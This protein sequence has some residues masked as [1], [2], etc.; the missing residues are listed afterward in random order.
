MT[1]RTQLRTPDHNTTLLAHESN[2]ATPPASSSLHSALRSLLPPPPLA[3]FCSCQ[4]SNLCGAVYRTGNVVFTPDGSALLSPTGNRITAFHLTTHRTSTLPVALPS[5]TQHLALS[6]SGHLLLAIDDHGRSLF[7]HYAHRHVLFEFAFGSP[8]IAVAFSPNG[9]YLAAATAPGTL[10]IYYTPQLLSATAHKP[11]TTLRQLT[12]HHAAI[13]HIDWSADSHYLLTASEDLTA[14]VVTLGDVTGWGGASGGLTLAGHR[15]TVVAAYWATPEGDKGNLSYRVY[16]ISQDGAL[17]QWRWVHTPA[18][19]STTA[20]SASLSSSSHPHHPPHTAPG[21][22]S[23]FGQPGR[24]I[25]S[26]KHFF[27]SNTHQST[28]T[29][30]QLHRT[31]QGFDLLLVAFS[32]GSFSLYELPAFTLIHSL[33]VSSSSLS[34]LAISPSSSW[35]AVGSSHTSSLLVWEWQSESYILRQQ[36][37]SGL[38]SCLAY[39]PDSGYIATGGDDG[40]VKVWNANSGYCFKTFTH[41]TAPVTSVLFS[42]AG[43][44]VLSASSDGTVHCY[45]LVRYR[46]F[47]TLTAPVACQFGAMC[48][49]DKGELVMVAAA[50]PF[51]VYV[52]ALQT[53]RL[54]DVLSGHE[55]PISE[56]GFSNSLSLLLS[57]SWDRTVR[58]WDPFEGKG[59]VEVLQHDSDVISLAVR[60]DG[61]A[62]ATATL[63]GNVHVWDIRTATVTH[64]IEVGKDIAGGRSRD[65]VRTAASRR[66]AGAGSGGYVTSMCWSADGSCLLLGSNTRHIA[67]YDVERKLLIKRFTI[68]RNESLDGTKD[69]LNSKYVNAPPTDDSTAAVDYLPGARTGERSERRWGRQVRSRC[70]RFAPTGMQWSAATNEGLLVYALDE[71]MIFDPTDLGQF[72]ARTQRGCGWCG[73]CCLL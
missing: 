15:T 66:A 48:M 31:T 41:H 52:F 27:A 60:N 56:V 43:N 40:R 59:C 1:G 7:I 47:R 30:S 13:T 72:T 20:V 70:V 12:P 50:E 28:I 32:S 65:D 11:L 10:T 51:V 58:V 23:L 17:L 4:F 53:G 35:L 67:I 2:D 63:H 44:V 73:V 33:S 24:F 38:V 16:T 14:R 37:H 8:V 62:V 18:A 25:L 61:L 3:V 34:T 21:T 6:P 29:A 49:D 39:T 42:S 9:R 68:S 36:G 57:S 54:L 71:E 5:T 64:V 26:S 46:L 55:A 22:L 19:S 45:D 69:T